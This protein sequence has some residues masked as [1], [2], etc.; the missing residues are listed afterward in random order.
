MG[1]PAAMRQDGGGRPPAE[2]GRALR[3]IGGYRYSVLMP[4]QVDVSLPT[5]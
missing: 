1:G 4:L 2:A 3:R 5:E